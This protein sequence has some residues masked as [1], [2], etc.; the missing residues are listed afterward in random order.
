MRYDPIHGFMSP[1]EYDR[2]VGFIEEQAAAGNLRELPVDKE[3][4]KGGIYGGRWFLDIENAERWRLV[5]PDFPFR[6][7]WEPIARPDY[8]EVS[9][10]SH[11]LQASHGLNACQCAGKLASA[12]HAEGKYE[13]G[14]F[15]RAV[16][17][18]LTPR[19]E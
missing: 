18:S 9:R 8:V 13:E 15:W 5:P 4:G 1:G 16:E 12:V 17:A 19:G 6:G 11:E 7:L 2:F 14:V 10:I 3:Y